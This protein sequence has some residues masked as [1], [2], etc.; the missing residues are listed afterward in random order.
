MTHPAV[1]DCAVQGHLVDGIGHLPRAYIVLRYG[2]TAS[3]E[4][5]LQV[6]HNIAVF[7]TS[8]MLTFP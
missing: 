8:K 7:K 6:W 3:A 2:Y 5:L 4:E 1:D